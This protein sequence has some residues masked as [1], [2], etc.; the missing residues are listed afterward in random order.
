M[1]SGQNASTATERTAA[2]VTADSVDASVKTVD[3]EASTKTHPR[4]NRRL[5]LAALVTLVASAAAAGTAVALTIA[6]RDDGSPQSTFDGALDDDTQHAID[7]LM[8]LLETNST[9]ALHGR[10]AFVQC[11]YEQRFG[12]CFNLKREQDVLPNVNVRDGWNTQAG[13]RPAGIASSDILFNNNAWTAYEYTNHRRNMYITHYIDTCSICS[14]SVFSNAV[15]A[16]IAVESRPL[17]FRLHQSAYE[18]FVGS[19]DPITD[20]IGGYVNYR[21]RYVR[22]G[23]GALG[24]AP[25][26]LV[27]QTFHGGST[28]TSF[29]TR[30]PGFFFY[31]TLESRNRGRV[32]V[33]VDSEPPDCCSSSS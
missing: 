30:G 14:S 8:H 16:F 3:L 2:D 17:M 15:Q 22:N 12:D 18:E 20:P 31:Y 5:I 28:T 10:R 7:D 13:A 29:A 32:L 9:S 25:E 6:T 24:T 23:A 11:W 33:V 1:A 4:R 26:E 21:Q 27:L 19:R